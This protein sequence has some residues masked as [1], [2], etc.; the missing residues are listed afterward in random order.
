MLAGENAPRARS[1]ADVGAAA[2]DL[3]RDFILRD[4]VPSLDC[5]AITLRSIGRS[6]FVA[7][8]LTEALG[9]RFTCN[10]ELPFDL[11]D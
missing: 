11:A 8:G 7:L 5:K 1:A 3:Q 2:I 4:A 6:D 10:Y 9:K